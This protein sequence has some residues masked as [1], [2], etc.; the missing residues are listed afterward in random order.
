MDDEEISNYLD[1]WMDNDAGFNAILTNKETSVVDVE[2]YEDRGAPRACVVLDDD[3]LLLFP[4]FKVPN[5]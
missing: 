1:H 5:N 3:L 4:P 2:Y